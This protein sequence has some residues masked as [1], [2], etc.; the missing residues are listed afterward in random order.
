MSQRYSTSLY[1]HIHKAESTHF[2]FVARNELIRDIVHTYIPEADGRTFL[3]V[4]CGTGI[5]LSVLGK[6]G[7]AM[8]GID[9]NERAIAYASRKT[10]AKLVRKTIL[11]Y[12]PSESFAAV[13]AFDV[14]EHIRDDKE[15]L[16]RCHELL[17]DK[18]LLFLT[19]PAGQY[20]WSPVDELSGHYRRYFRSGLEKLLKSSGFRVETVGHW[21]TLLLPMYM[22]WRMLPSRKSTDIMQRYLKTP[23]RFVN[24]LLLGVLQAENLFG[25]GKWPYGATLVA[26]ARKV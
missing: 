4:G 14:L 10:N 20:L 23:N 2:W 3:D 26:V 17:D 9:V 18:G 7:F 6:L 11:Q 5:M 21:N 16:L 25:Q 8:T 12:Q 24:R 22:L 15:F 1:K 19:L 13:G